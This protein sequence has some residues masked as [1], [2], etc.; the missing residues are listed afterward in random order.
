MK[1][2]LAVAL[3]LCLLVP[4]AAMAD[5]PA[6][7]LFASQYNMYA[8]GL[9]GVQMLDLSSCT[10]GEDPVAGYKTLTFIDGEAM[11][12]AFVDY[13]RIVGGMV[14][15]PDARSSLDFLCRCAALMY[16]V[17]GMKSDNYSQLFF[18]MNEARVKAQETPYTADLATGS[19][20]TMMVHEG[21]FIFSIE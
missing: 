7:L 21:S 16:C 6:I 9:F 5:D 1:K 3:V 8:E 12:T 15:Q 17:D 2:L 10:V 13:E 18:V 11:I 20:I 19:T 14:M 4:C